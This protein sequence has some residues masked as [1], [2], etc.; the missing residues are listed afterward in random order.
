MSTPS[1]IPSFLALS[2]VLTGFTEFELNGT[3]QT[4][5]YFSTLSDVV[6]AATVAEL[7]TTFTTLAEA[8]G[9][10][11]EM[12]DKTLRAEILSSEKLGPVARNLIKLWYIGT[13]Y[14][15]PAGWHKAFGVGSEDKDF[16][17]HPS[18]Y[19]EGLLWPAI[20]AHPPGA[21]AP[22]YGTWTDAPKIPKVPSS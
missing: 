12:L 22:G 7:L 8:A 20:G 10:D 11:A 18:S 14:Q 13:W 17:P 19:V 2:E 5:R 15:L 16:V 3:G 4:Q 9:D 21:K 6:G 1:E